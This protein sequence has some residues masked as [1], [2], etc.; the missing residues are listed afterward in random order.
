MWNI[1]NRLVVSVIQIIDAVIQNIV[2]KQEGN[3][4]CGARAPPTGLVMTLFL[5][6]V[7]ANIIY[8]LHEG[9]ELPEQT[10]YHEM[11]EELYLCLSNTCAK[12]RS[13]FGGNSLNFRLLPHSRWGDTLSRSVISD[14]DGGEETQSYQGGGHKINTSF[15]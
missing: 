12:N 3:L 9:D 5:T 14:G 13:L 10:S 4:Y 8:K 11:S 7:V 1:R 2:R 15:L 6:S